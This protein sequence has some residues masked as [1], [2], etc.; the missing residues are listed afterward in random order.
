MLTNSIPIKVLYPGYECEIQMFKG[1]I[2]MEI[3]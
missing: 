2:W 3:K 1:I